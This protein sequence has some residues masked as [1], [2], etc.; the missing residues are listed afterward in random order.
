VHSNTA[1]LHIHT[2]GSHDTNHRKDAKRTPCR[3]TFPPPTCSFLA[4][5]RSGAHAAANESG[6]QAVRINCVTVK[7]PDL[8]RMSE[9]YHS[10]FGMPLKQQSA[11]THILGVGSSGVEQENR[12]TPWVDRFDFGIANLDADDARAK[13]RNL[14][15]KYDRSN[16]KESF[17][18]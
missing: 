14:N 5:F 7:I 8:H 16:S 2:K 1:V 4:A 10:F 3:Q 11:K 15:L 18:F 13:L 6:L 17:K 9:F 12:P